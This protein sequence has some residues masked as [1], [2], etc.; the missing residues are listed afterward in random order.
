MP[1]FVRLSK[2]DMYRV[3]RACA[4]SLADIAKFV[5]DDIRVGVLIEIYLRLAQDPSKLVK[6]SILQQSGMFIAS[7]PSRTV[8]EVILGH[9]CSMATSPTG[10][11]TVDAELRHYCAY[12]FPAVLQTIGVSRWHE[13]RELYHALVHS[14]SNQ[15]KQTLASSLHEIA[16]LLGSDEMNGGNV[17]EGNGDPTIATNDHSNG[18]GNSPMN[19]SVNTNATAGGVQLV[20]DELIP[21]FETLLQDVEAVQMGIMRHLADF[22][23]QLSMP[24]RVSYLPLLHDLLHSTNPFNW[25]LRQCLAVQL[26][27]LLKLPPPD[28]VFNTLFPL[29]MTLL[30][31]PVASVRKDSFRGV[32]RMLLILC[33]QANALNPDHKQSYLP[34]FTPPPGITFSLR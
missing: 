21:V 24:C 13:V 32:A 18:A 15:V 28:L 4:E 23:S 33:E 26:P 27:D 6:Q 2:D 20:E 16:R 5:G 19:G 22:F 17:S 7:L 12:S 25:R 8:S 3:R 9:F 10:D 11:A 34:I 1:A 14:R 31:D 29:V 30:Q